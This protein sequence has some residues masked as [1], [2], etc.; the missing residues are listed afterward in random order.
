MRRERGGTRPPDSR[1]NYRTQN[2]RLQTAPRRRVPLREARARGA[3]SASA[4]AMPRKFPPST[5]RSK[6]K[7]PFAG[8]PRGRAGKVHNSADCCAKPKGEIPTAVGFCGWAKGPPGKGTGSYSNA[9]VITVKDN[10]KG[11]GCGKLWKSSGARGGQPSA[12]DKRLQRMRGRL[13][14]PGSN[15][16]DSRA[17]RRGRERRPRRGLNSRELSGF[18]WESAIEQGGGPCGR[19]R[20]RGRERQGR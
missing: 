20:A 2:E 4:P 19:K 1:K 13:R 9:G 3:P 11:T 17:G 6:R 5:D 15:G 16:V 14:G 12:G 7:F 18:L 8:W 10:N